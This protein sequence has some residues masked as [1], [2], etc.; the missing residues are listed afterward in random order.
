M[1]QAA[2]LLIERDIDAIIV[3]Q[4]RVLSLCQLASV[5]KSRL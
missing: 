4:V 3:D 5:V 1:S 2:L